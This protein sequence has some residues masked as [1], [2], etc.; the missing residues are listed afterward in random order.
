MNIYEYG[1]YKFL[2]NTYY[3]LLN[4]TPKTLKS[5]R[6]QIQKYAC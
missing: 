6:N 2:L 3:D 4:K 5:F 1:F